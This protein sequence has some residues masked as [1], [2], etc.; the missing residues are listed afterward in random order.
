[1]SMIRYNFPA[2]LPTDVW[3][4]L[5][6]LFGSSNLDWFSPETSSMSFRKGFPKVDAFR[7]KDGNLTI[8]F[9]LAGYSK[10]DLSVE[11]DGNMLK[12]SANK[13]VGDECGEQSRAIARRAFSKSYSVDSGWDLTGA[14]VTHVDGVLTVAVP[15][16]NPQSVSKTLTIE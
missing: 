1:M 12:V 6:R 7:S 14:K 15:P 9:A 10:N 13:V 3:S 2:L 5:D 4:D 11:V 8:Q 16:T